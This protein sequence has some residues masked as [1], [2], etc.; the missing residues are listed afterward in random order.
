MMCARVTAADAT[1]SRWC[2]SADSSLLR[3]DYVSA[4][5]SLGEALRVDPRHP[6]AIYRLIMIRQTEI[7]DYESYVIH[8]RGFIRYSDS[9]LQVLKI[10]QSGLRGR[11]S[12]DCLFYVANTVG[13]RA[14]IQAKVGNWFAAIGDAYTSMN[15]L[16]Q[17][18]DADS[19][20]LAAYL[21]LGIFDY[22][23]SQNLKWIP[24]FGDRKKE[25]IRNI[26]K[27]AGAPFPFDIGAKNTLCWILI[28]Q[29]RYAEADSICRAV[30]DRYPDNSV[31]LR[32]ASCI[33][34]WT[35]EWSAAIGEGRRLI[36][37][38]EK[39]TPVNWSDLLAGYWVLV[40]CYNQL[41]NT[42]ECARAADRALALKIPEP[43]A[44]ISYVQ[45]HLSSIRKVRHSLPVE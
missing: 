22:Y 27:A 43:Y 10:V 7:L 15:L 21:G 3:Q 34:H 36:A 13:G 17:I 31:F 35:H 42:S 18:L 39:R 40:D 26:R 12:L 6:G 29:D 5:R 20:Y 8:G 41:G 37:V 45:Q 32:V 33:R 4:T 24:W 14:V 9:L 28:E 19:A 38:S 30:L 16:H 25:G 44:K 11:D 1:A 23:L 2:D